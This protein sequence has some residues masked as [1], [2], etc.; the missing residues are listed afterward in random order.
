M[1]AESLIRARA[2]QAEVRSRPETVY[3]CPKGDP[4]H[5]ITMLIPVQGIGCPHGVMKKVS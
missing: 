3:T 5:R 4:Q 2:A 1:S